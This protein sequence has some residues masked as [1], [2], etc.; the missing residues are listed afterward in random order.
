MPVLRWL[1]SK[2]RIRSPRRTRPTGSVA[3]HHRGHIAPRWEWRQAHRLGAT[4]QSGPQRKASHDAAAGT[5]GSG[6]SRSGTRSGTH[7][8]AGAEPTWSPWRQLSDPAAVGSRKRKREELSTIERGRRRVGG[9]GGGHSSGS[10]A[11]LSGGTAQLCSAA[12]VQHRPQVDL[13]GRILGS[14]GEPRGVPSTSTRAGA[15][16]SRAAVYNVYSI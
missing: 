6:P 14:G 15:S 1:G 7:S 10:A 8:H 3:V 12:P 16:T 13:A 4:S 9:R 11:R 2:T 5:S